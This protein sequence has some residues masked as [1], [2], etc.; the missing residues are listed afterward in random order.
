MTGG[1]VRRRFDLLE[2][3]DHRLRGSLGTRVRLA[4]RAR[5]FGPIDLSF[6]KESALRTAEPVAQA[7]PHA[8]EMGI[9][10]PGKHPGAGQ[11]QEDCAREHANQGTDPKRVQSR[12]DSAADGR[13]TC[14]PQRPT[15]AWGSGY[16][17]TCCVAL[18]A[19][20]AAPAGSRVLAVAR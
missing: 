16:A 17:D 13:A 14:Q 6:A 15:Q 19:A 9:A 1:Q 10:T 12:Q 18:N 5:S 4:A 11:P 7:A 2:L 8:H 20:C 3:I